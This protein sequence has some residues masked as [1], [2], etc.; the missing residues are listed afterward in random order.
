MNA[1]A[2]VPSEST[3]VL[4]DVTYSINGKALQPIINSISLEIHAGETLVLLGD[5]FAFE[6]CSQ[7][8]ADDPT[9]PG[10][11]HDILRTPHHQRHERGA[12]LE[13]SND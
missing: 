9:A 5:T 13:D 6:V 2:D 4:H 3:I 12:E 7:G 11:C 1:K 8:G 10:Q